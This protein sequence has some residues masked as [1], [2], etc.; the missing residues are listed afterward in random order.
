[1][2]GDIETQPRIVKLPASF[3][4]TKKS[5]MPLQLIAPFLILLTVG[6]NTAAQTLLKL[7]AGQGLLN[8]YSVG[9]IL[10]YGLSTI[11][12][13]FVLGKFN[14]SFAYPVVI[15]LTVI[16]TTLSGV[17]LLQEKVSAGQWVGIGLMLS[18]ICAIAFAKTS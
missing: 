6:L 10:A 9:G 14:L 18:S 2:G 13:L 5:S 12:Y 3:I 4:V 11:T 16:A 15:G 7:G 8:L 1:V 17:M